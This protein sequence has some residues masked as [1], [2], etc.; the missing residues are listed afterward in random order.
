LVWLKIAAFSRDL[1]VLHKYMAVEK[2]S[3]ERQKARAKEKWCF[4]RHVGCQL[5]IQ[6][7]PRAGEPQA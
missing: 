4:F 2:N 7:T 1:G 3:C 5:S 6:D